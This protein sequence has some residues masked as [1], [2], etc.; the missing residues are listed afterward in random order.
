MLESMDERRLGA[1]GPAAS[2][3]GLGC[4]EMSGTYG[5]SDDGE[6]ISDDPRRARRVAI[7]RLNHY[8]RSQRELN[9]SAHRRY[10]VEPWW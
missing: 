2:A 1:S 4:S 7:E 9:P 5:A 6:S 3:L 10:P 8:T